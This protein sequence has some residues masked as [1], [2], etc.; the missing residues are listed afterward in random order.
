MKPAKSL[1]PITERKLLRNHN[2]LRYVVG[3]DEVGRGCWAGPLYMA[4]F[5][6]CVENANQVL[7]LIHDS[8]L[9]SKKRRQDIVV[10]LQKKKL[11]KYFALQD[12]PITIINEIGLGKSLKLALDN[13]I[14]QFNPEQTYFLLDGNLKPTAKGLNYDVIIKG[15]AK[16]YS[17]ALAANYAKTRRDNY[18]RNIALQYPNYGFENHVGYGTKFHREALLRYGPTDIHR[19]HYKPI[20]AIL[21]KQLQFAV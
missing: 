19:A 18:M 9:T 21:S 3:I 6:Y 4:G 17:I 8:K 7:R 10:Q 15:D 1:R 11:E 13:I 20:S 5:I 2:G 12:I 16:I 14:N